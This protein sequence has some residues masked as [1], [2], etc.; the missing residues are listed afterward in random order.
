[1]LMKPENGMILN[2]KIEDHELVKMEIQKL[3]RV[4]LRVS[5]DTLQ[6]TSQALPGVTDLQGEQIAKRSNSMLKRG[7]W[8]R[9]LTDTRESNQILMVLGGIQNRT[10]N[11][12]T[13]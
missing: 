8:S 1:M 11:L 9:V 4:G 10:F 6:T 5:L 13:T 7:Q 3:V 12:A 2:R